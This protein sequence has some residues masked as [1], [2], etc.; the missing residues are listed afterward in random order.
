MPQ[1]IYLSVGWGVQ[2]F[3]I[4]AMVALGELPSIDLALHADTGHEAEGTYQHAAKWTPWLQA[5]GLKIVTVHPKDNQVVSTA[6]GQP[7]NGGHVQI[8]AF[9][10]DKTD[11]SKEG[12]IPRQCTRYWKIK[13]MHQ[14]VR[15][16]LP[17]GKPQPEAV[18][19]WQGISLDEFHRSRTSDVK[20]IKN[21]Y[22]LVELAP[23]RMT[24][25]DCITWLNQR[26]LD[27]P[28]KSSCVFCPF[29]RIAQWKAMKKQAGPDWEKAVAIDN[30]IRETR[31]KH[32]LFIHQTK[33]PLEQA[34]KIPEDLGASQLELDLPCDSGYCFV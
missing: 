28:P 8:P 22:P 26:G 17:K 6:W 24:R 4:A 20:Y 18:H 34:V 32:R 13:P 21:V 1:L 11:R 16:L 3:T 5:R 27:I 10:L 19:S 30:D 33:L 23:T 12:Q 25:A 29:H 2:S 9:S 14:Y 7:N 31:R 15:S